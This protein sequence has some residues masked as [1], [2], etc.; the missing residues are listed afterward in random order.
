MSEFSEMLKEA[1][2]GEE[3]FDPQPG[4]EALDASVKK[5]DRRMRTVQVMV[6]LAVT[7]MGVVCVWSAV[8]FFRARDDGGSA[9]VLY[10]VVFL[11]AQ[12]GIGFLKMW[13]IV[14]QNHIRTMK[15]LKRVQMMLL[16]S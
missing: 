2:V 4:R 13:L 9:L 15:E 12:A 8:A 5:F 16:A 6:W 14:M 10:A 11:W 7:F 1:F 3:P